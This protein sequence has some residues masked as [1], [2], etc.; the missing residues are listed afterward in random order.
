MKNIKQMKPEN[1]IYSPIFGGLAQGSLTF[2]KKVIVWLQI[3]GNSHI[4]VFLGM[5]LLMRTLNVLSTSGSFTM[6]NLNSF[7]SR[8]EILLIA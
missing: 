7:L 4:I 5:M 2:G 1:C 3:R 8:S 6:A